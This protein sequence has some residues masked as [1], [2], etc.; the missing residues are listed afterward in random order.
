MDNLESLKDYLGYGMGPDEMLRLEEALEVDELKL[1]LWDGGQFVKAFRWHDM[2]GERYFDMKVAGIGEAPYKYVA[3][4]IVDVTES[5]LIEVENR[6]N[7]R[8]VEALSDD[9]RAVFYIDAKTESVRLYRAD[10]DVIR[11]FGGYFKKNIRYSD[12]VKIY[13][14]NNALI[15]EG[16]EAYRYVECN[17]LLEDVK[18]KGILTLNYTRLLKGERRQYRLK[19]VKVEEDGV[20]KGI[21]LGF[22]DVEEEYRKDIET[23]ELLRAASRRFGCAPR[24]H[25]AVRRARRGAR[26]RRGSPRRCACSRARGRRL[27]GT[28][29]P[30]ADP[31]RRRSSRSRDA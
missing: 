5:K 12:M 7:S 17:T 21:V 18:K 13:I 19:A 22:R 23:Q 11:R 3:I 6:K 28:P 27:R 26:A 24:A 1:R 4:G 25:P 8:I 30:C 16:D 29:R 14:T 10:E 20:F 2:S 9:Y 15:R 31:V